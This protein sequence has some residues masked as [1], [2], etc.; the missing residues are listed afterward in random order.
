LPR[1]SLETFEKTAGK[2]RHMDSVASS[3]VQ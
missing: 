2:T 1:E 3:T